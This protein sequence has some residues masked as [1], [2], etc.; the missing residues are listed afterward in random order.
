MLPINKQQQPFINNHTSIKIN[1]HLSCNS[2]SP[3]YNPLVIRIIE[4]PIPIHQS[5]NA[6]LKNQ[7]SAVTSPGS[8]LCTPPRAPSS[9]RH[10]LPAHAPSLPEFFLSL[11]SLLSPRFYARAEPAQLVIYCRSF[12]PATYS[13]A[14]AAAA[15]AAAPPLARGFITPSRR[16]LF[17]TP[18]ANAPPRWVPSCRILY[19]PLSGVSPARL[20][21]W[22]DF[23]FWRNMVLCEN[24]VL[25]FFSR[26]T[27][28]R[29]AW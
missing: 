6:H 17:F 10:F 27:L 14:T 13:R 1:I 28:S 26:I 3:L 18:R 25:D 22:G 20:G 29:I 16:E 2:H 21:C 11:G 5:P 12:S 9:L 23:F 8:S 19:T 4:L 7:Q 24:V 15:A